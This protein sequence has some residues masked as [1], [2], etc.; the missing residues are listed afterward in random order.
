ML[1]SG[2]QAEDARDCPS[3]RDLRHC[4]IQVCEVM[5]CLKDEETQHVVVGVLMS[6]VNLGCLRCV[7]SS[8]GT[9]AQG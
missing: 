1:L 6:N 7:E 8:L 9:D 3:S 5:G 4:W 2:L